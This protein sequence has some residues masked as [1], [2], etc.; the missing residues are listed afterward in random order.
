MFNVRTTDGEIAVFGGRLPFRS[1]FAT[2]GVTYTK[3]DTIRVGLDYRPNGLS[4]GDPATIEYTLTMGANTYSSGPLAFDEGN[5]SEDPP[6]GLWG[7]LSPAYVGGHMQMFLGDSGVGNTMS[8]TWAN[9]NFVPEPA[10]LLL[11]GLG[12]LAVIRKR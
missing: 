1:F 8:V 3:G 7:M 6:H 4:A 12:A 11:L 2:D 9:I 10:S 5:T